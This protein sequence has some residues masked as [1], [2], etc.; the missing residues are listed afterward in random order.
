MQMQI[1]QS[2]GS[3][4]EKELEGLND[5]LKEMQGW[6]A[7]WAISDQS[8]SRFVFFLNKAFRTFP[9]HGISKANGLVGANGRKEWKERSTRA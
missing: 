2:D 1:R 6:G 3:V 7:G 5:F 4:A 9:V 8:K